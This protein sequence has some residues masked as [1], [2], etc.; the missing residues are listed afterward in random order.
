M[1]T[2]FHREESI[3]GDCE[4]EVDTVAKL[5]SYFVPSVSETT[6][7]SRLGISTLPRSLFESGGGTNEFVSGKRLVGWNEFVS[8]VEVGRF[9]TDDWFAP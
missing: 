4:G 1:E 3:R 7:G 5:E 8:T 9:K 6:G 2:A